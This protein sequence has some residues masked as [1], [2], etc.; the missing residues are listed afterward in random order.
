MQRRFLKTRVICALAILQFAIA[1]CFSDRHRDTIRLPNSESSSES[2]AG[3]TSSSYTRPVTIV[4]RLKRSTHFDATPRRIVSLS[5]ATTELVF[6]L[7]A[8]ELLVGSTDYCDYP[9]PAKSIPRVGSGPLGTVSLEA[10][11]GKQPDLVL[12]KFDTHQPLVESLERLKIAV[13]AVGPE[14]LEEFF[15]EARWLGAALNRNEQAEQLIQAMS[16]KKEQLATKSLANRN[17]RVFYQVWN[18]PLMT[19]GKG[20]FINQLLELA[21]LENVVD[22]TIGRYPRVSPELV[23]ERDPEI[24]IVPSSPANPV[25]LETIYGRPGW[26]G[27]S[28][29]KNRR[30]LVVNSDIISRCGPRMLDALEQII[31]AIQIK[32]G[33]HA[34]GNL[35]EKAG[36]N[37]VTPG[38]DAALSGG[39]P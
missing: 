7:G 11:V 8:G 32:A 28:A 9:E 17:L 30:V 23:V 3:A 16:A 31:E 22:A 19:A 38:K 24:I 39:Q 29:V 6:A 13:V 36:E 33:E 20:S 25:D 21:G 26:Q 34:E 27:V 1:G 5:P 10:I 15:E 12:C 2:R 18:D 14:S 37:T 35:G 4:D